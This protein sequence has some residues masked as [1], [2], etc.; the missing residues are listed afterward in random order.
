MDFKFKILLVVT[1]LLVAATVAYATGS[2]DDLLPGFADGA[3]IVVRHT[4]PPSGQEEGPLTALRVHKGPDQTGGVLALSF[5]LD[6][7]ATGILTSA[8]LQTASDV[9]GDGLLDA[10]EWTTIA[11]ATISEVAGKTHAASA[12]VEVAGDLDA[13]RIVYIRN[14]IGETIETWINDPNVHLEDGSE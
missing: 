9:N 7:E 13:Y 6:I 1:A 10:G 11:T 4:R 8:V 2:L 5:E 12:S 3:T 14:D